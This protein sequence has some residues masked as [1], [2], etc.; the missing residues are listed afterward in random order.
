[1]VTNPASTN[2]KIHLKNI[3]TPVIAFLIPL[4]LV[5]VVQQ[6][7]VHVYYVPS[8]SMEQTLYTNDRVL[9]LATPQ[10]YQPERGEII[11]FEDTNNWLDKKPNGENQYLVKRVLGLP[12]ETIQCCDANNN[13]II[14]GE[15]YPENYI[16]PGSNEPF[17]PQTVPEGHVFVLGDNR[18]YSADSRYHITENTQ[19]INIH[20]IEAKVFF[21]FWP[22]THFGADK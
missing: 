12:G 4:V 13:L 1:M 15:P 8:A 2:K 20:T 22:F 10:N 18:I 7:W 17:A 16:I 11:I 19:F 9:G 6:Y 5:W 3:L 14:N 21:T